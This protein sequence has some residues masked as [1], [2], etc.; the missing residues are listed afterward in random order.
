MPPGKSDEELANNFAEYFLEKIDKIRL[1]F[2]GIPDY[3]SETGNVPRLRRFHPFAESEVKSKVM[4]MQSKS[5]ELDAMPTPLLK[6]LIDKCIPYITR[7][8]NIP[9]THGVFSMQWK[10]SIV[11]PLLKKAGLALINKNKRPVSNLSFL[12]KLLERCALKQFNSHCDM[13]DLIPDFQS[14]YHSA[15]SKETSLLKLSNDILWGIEKQEITVVILLDLSAAFDT[16]DHDLL[17]SILE[18]RYGITD[19]ALKWYQSYLSPR[20]MKVCT[21][22]T[23]SDSLNIKYGVPQGN[24]SGVNNFVAYCAPIQ[25]I[26]KDK[27]VGLSGYA[28]DH[29]I[30]K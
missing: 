2:D 26:I 16:I 19:Q 15:Y 22:S 29:S 9:L 18:D 6:K 25:N 1:M 12:S 8:I 21:N 13:Y 5:C 10:T 14:A 11:R 3:K 20:E 24:C 23:Y 17:L 7:I 27:T 4:S 28:D 30:C